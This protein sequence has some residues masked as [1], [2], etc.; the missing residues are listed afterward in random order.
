MRYKLICLKIGGGQLVYEIFTHQACSCE[1][2][3]R[4]S[5]FKS[6]ALLV[7]DLQLFTL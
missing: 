4:R 3:P 6:N 2:Q 1:P 5:S 7:E